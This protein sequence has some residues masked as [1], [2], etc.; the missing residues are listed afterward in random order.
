MKDDQSNARAAR[1]FFIIAIRMSDSEHN[2]DFEPSDEELTELSVAVGAIHSEA[3]G[4]ALK[5]GQSRSTASAAGVAAAKA[6]E[7]GYYRAR[8]EG[9]SRKAAD[10]AAYAAGD[11]IVAG[12]S[13]TEAAAAGDAAGKAA[14]A[15][16]S[17]CKSDIATQTESNTAMQSAAASD[18]AGASAM[19][20][21]SGKESD[22]EED[23]PLSERKKRMK[24]KQQ[25][26]RAVTSS[27]GIAPA[28]A[29]ASSAAAPARRPS[30]ASAKGKRRPAPPAP[31][32]VAAV[33]WVGGCRRTEGCV[34]EFRHRGSCR[35]A[36][37][38]EVEYEVES[39]LDERGA[40]RRG[41]TQ[42]LV[43]WK[44]WPVEDATWEDPESLSGAQEVVQEWWDKG[45]AGESVAEPRGAVGPRAAAPQGR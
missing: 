12:K 26:G 3:E 30:L 15:A 11:A 13:P 24:L 37:F 39:I 6:A 7:A 35:V 18:N 27:G 38:E 4:A 40:A 8:E 34:K 23:E 5:N 43:K 9:F 16:L 22:D 14:E 41:E 21:R 20:S 25:H 29:S 44:G 33:A 10:F 2:D 32:A 17:P 31:E 28:E 36:A 45:Q 19:M 1:D 42:F